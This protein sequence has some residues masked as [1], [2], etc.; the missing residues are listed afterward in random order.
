M[1]YSNRKYQKETINEVIEENN[2]LSNRFNVHG[3]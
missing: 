1:V 3:Q 2:Q